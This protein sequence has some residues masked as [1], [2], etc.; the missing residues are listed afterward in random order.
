MSD[1]YQPP[2]PDEPTP[3]SGANPPPG[4]GQQPPGYG[5]QPPGPYG[6]P[7]PENPQQPGQQQP[8]YP[9]AGY[10]PPYTPDPPG[11]VMGI[12]GFVLAFVFAPAGIVVSAL[13]LSDSKKVGYDNVL[14]K[15]GLW[16]S[17]IFTS[18]GVLLVIGYLVFFIAVFGTMGTEMTV[19]SGVLSGV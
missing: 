2:Q 6:T 19:S 10:P 5:Q 9:P 3:P 7:P 14:G 1:P 13:A 12:V 8:G 4:Y 16:L 11:K 17:I 15:W 18:I